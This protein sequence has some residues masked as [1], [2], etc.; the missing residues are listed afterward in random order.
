MKSIHSTVIAFACLSLGAASTGCIAAPAADDA[1]AT[2]QAQNAL[3]VA[4]L[5]GLAS[6]TISSPDYAD[7]VV[8]PGYPVDSLYTFDTKLD[9]GSIG[10]TLQV[11]AYVMGKSTV[12]TLV[13][14]YGVRFD[15]IYSWKSS[16]PIVT[17][18]YTS[19]TVSKYCLLTHCTT[20]IVRKEGPPPQL[21]H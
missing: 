6:C 1:E 4:D 20:T 15:A 11:K 21:T 12:G 3:V 9:D 14:L 2:S 17:K 10:P 18:S 13:R 5:G 7:C 19:P 16:G 8:S